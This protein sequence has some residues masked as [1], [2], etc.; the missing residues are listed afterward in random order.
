MATPDL[1][2]SS[3]Q[4]RAVEFSKFGPPSVLQLRTDYP[5][6][7]CTSKQVLIKI[8]A[9]SVNPVDIGIRQGNFM[10]LMTKKP[11]V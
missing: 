11:N 10:A 6:P 2:T 7:I 3:S 1:G 9:A 4:M 5:K 8:H